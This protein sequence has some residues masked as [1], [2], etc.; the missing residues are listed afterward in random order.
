MTRL[1]FY[2]NGRVFQN[3]M[4]STLRFVLFSLKKENQRNSIEEISH[5]EHSK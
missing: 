4:I 5:R 3:L 2:E 1:D